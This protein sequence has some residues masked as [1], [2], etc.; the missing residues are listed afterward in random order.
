MI[1]G[2]KIDNLL[3]GS[4]FTYESPTSPFIV[5]GI[6]GLIRQGVSVDGYSFLL[7][8]IY[9]MM[10]DYSSEKVNSV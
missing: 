7:V 1:V 9:R 10:A 3:L 4:S 5:R 8:A 6:L 2:G